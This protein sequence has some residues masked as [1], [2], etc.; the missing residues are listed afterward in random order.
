MF[1]ADDSL[2]TITN[3]MPAI[4]PKINLVKHKVSAYSC[5]FWGKFVNS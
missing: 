3:E 1:L 4:I 2:L 5:V